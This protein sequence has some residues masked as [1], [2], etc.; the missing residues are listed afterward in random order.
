M[1]L[2]RW[3]DAIEGIVVCLFLNGKTDIIEAA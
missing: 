3:I 1:V 2:G